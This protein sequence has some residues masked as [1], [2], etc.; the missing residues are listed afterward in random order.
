VLVQQQMIVK[1]KSVVTDMP[2]ENEQ[3]PSEK[4]DALG[5]QHMYCT[6]YQKVTRH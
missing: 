6:A 1:K 2:S 3:K 5:R 4:T